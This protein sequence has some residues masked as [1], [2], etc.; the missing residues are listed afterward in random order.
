[1]KYFANRNTIAGIPDLLCCVNGYFMALE[2]KAEHGRPSKLQEY[3]VEEIQ[4]AKGIALI[5][6]PKDYDR[7][8]ELLDKLQND[9]YTPT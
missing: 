1:M 2:I 8:I 3:Q 7:L 4:K 5:V 6:Y 9:T